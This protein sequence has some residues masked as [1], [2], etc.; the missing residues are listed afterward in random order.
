MVANESMKTQTKVLLVLMVVVVSLLAGLGG[1]RYSN[2]QEQE[3]EN[4]SLVNATEEVLVEELNET[5]IEPIIGNESLEEI[6]ENETIEEEV[7][8]TID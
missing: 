4:S 2:V 3:L 6:I 8:E 1:Y 7:N 5:V